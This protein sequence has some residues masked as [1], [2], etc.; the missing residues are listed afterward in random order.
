MLDANGY[1]VISAEDERGALALAAD[2]GGKL[3]ALVTDFSMPGIN[4]LALADE[5]CRKHTDLKV[6][7]AS[8]HTDEI[9]RSTKPYDLSVLEK[10]YTPTSLLSLLQEI[11]S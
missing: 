11:L 9:G 8:G 10:P 4:G 2:Y 5:L 1:N 6:I 3:A 7:L